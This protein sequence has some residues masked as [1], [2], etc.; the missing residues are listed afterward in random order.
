MNINFTGKT[1]NKYA[2]VNKAYFQT[3]DGQTVGIDRLDTDYTVSDGKLTMRWIRCYLWEIDG[4]NPFESEEQALTVYNDRMLKALLT[5]A[6]FLYIELEDDAD[7]DYE[8]TDIKVRLDIPAPKFEVKTRGGI[9][10]AEAGLDPFNPGVSVCYKPDGLDYEVDVAYIEN[11]DPSLPTAKGYEDNDLQILTYTDPWTDEYTHSTVL[12]DSEV[13]KA[14][15]SKKWYSFEERKPEAG[16]EIVWVD[17]LAK[18][19]YDYYN[20]GTGNL[21]TAGIKPAADWEWMY[22]EKFD[23]TQDDKAI[24]YKINSKNLIQDIALD[25]YVSEEPAIA[26]AMLEIP[27]CIDIE[28]NAYWDEV[29][30]KDYLS[31]FICRCDEADGWES[32]GYADD[33]LGDD[34]DPD[35]R[36][37]ALKK[38]GW[39]QRLKKDMAQKLLRV[40]KKTKTDIPEGTKSKLYLILSEDNKKEVC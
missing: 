38:S 26:L 2:M 27:E 13:R 1:N 7:D 37:I 14:L 25:Q 23:L 22:R 35:T 3:K 40:I 29:S 10:T 24:K 9:L 6:K 31:Y 21:I 18:V 20:P 5:D 33:I 12:K 15:A 17:D 34:G 28:L 16:K 32:D 19:D 39:E 4:I 8:V 11:T 36:Y 30:R